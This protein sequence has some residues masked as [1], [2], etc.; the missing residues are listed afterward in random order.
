MKKPFFGLWVLYAMLFVYGVTLSWFVYVGPYLTN[1]TLKALTHKQQRVVISLTTT[2]YRIDKIQATLESL[3]DQSIKVER[4]YLNIPYI[5]ERDNIPYVIPKWLESYTAVTINR[6]EDFGPITKL[7]PTLDAETDPNTI[8]ITVDDDVWYPRHVVRDLV[9]YA[10]QHPEVAVTPINIDFKLTE[11]LDFT[12]IKHKFKNG[13]DTKL[14]VGAAGVAY[15]R[16]FFAHDFAK[17]FAT[18]PA[19]CT[20]ADDLVISMYLAYN[21]IKIEQT[22]HNS[23]NP[24]VVPF[25]YKEME[26]NRTPDALKYGESDL[27]GNQ[28]RYAQCLVQLNALNLSG[29]QQK[30]L[31]RIQISQLSN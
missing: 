3:C 27:S 31:S 1:K 5:F 14:V 15:R 13:A 24:I 12:H 20:L 7:L 18:L 9:A 6:T 2:P 8:I 16:R 29:F 11:N 10:M 17:L 28:V 22:I 4:I 26:Y 19:P 21:H 25:T 30:F 23:F